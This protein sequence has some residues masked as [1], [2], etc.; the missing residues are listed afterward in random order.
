MVLY[1]AI[2]TLF[3]IRD[4]VPFANSL[5]I[6]TKLSFLTN[7]SG[8]LLIRDTEQ[9]KQLDKV[10][11]PVQRAPHGPEKILKQEYHNTGAIVTVMACYSRGIEAWWDASI[12][13][14]SYILK[15]LFIPFV[16][17]LRRETVDARKR[18]IPVLYQTQDTCVYY[19]KGLGCSSLHK[20]STLICVYGALK[21]GK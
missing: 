1:C 15:W 14:A 21:H 6:I 19:S 8:N 18:K 2:T 3:V 13:Q 4:I 9:L 12:M 5:Q 10:D 17:R 20:E 16:I 7:R 11:L